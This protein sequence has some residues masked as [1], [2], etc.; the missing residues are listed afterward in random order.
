M[1]LALHSICR[2]WLSHPLHLW[3][4]ILAATYLHRIFHGFGSPLWSHCLLFLIPWMRSSWKWSFISLILRIIK[5]LVLLELTVE[6]IWHVIDFI[7]LHLIISIST[8]TIKSILNWSHLIVY[9]LILANFW[10]KRW[11]KGASGA[12]KWLLVWVEWLGTCFEFGWLRSGG[13]FLRNL[14]FGV[15]WSYSLIDFGRKSV[16]RRRWHGLFCLENW[17]DIFNTRQLL[18]KALSKMIFFNLLFIQSCHI[19]KF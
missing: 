3:K 19:V 5:F 6:I 1:L 13:K 15:G 11:N 8:K 9:C 17:S 10:W 14:S 12:Q 2:R 7:S 18:T 4:T 16:H